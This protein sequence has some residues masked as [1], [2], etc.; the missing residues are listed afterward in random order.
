MPAKRRGP[1]KRK[2]RPRTRPRRR[3][4][5]TKAHAIAVTVNGTRQE[6]SVAPRVLLVD[7]L[8]DQLHLTGTHIGCDTSQCGACTVLLE[9]RP[10]KSCSV[11]AVQADGAQVT[12]IEGLVTR[13]RLHPI[14]EAFRDNRGVQCGYCTPGMVLSAYALLESNPSPTEDEIR[15]ALSG[16]LCRCTGYKGIVDSVAAAASRGRADG[17]PA[18]PREP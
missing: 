16:N 17:A 11:F 8:R 5:R 1:A 18:S 12:T 13:G 6:R 14:Q 9:G 3:A 15:V 4:L 2:T 10:V 7:F